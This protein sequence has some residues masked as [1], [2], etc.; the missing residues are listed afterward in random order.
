MVSLSRPSPFSVIRNSMRGF[1]ALTIN[2][3]RAS[4]SFF[5]VPIA[6]VAFTVT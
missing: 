4:R 3:P 5:I 2:S 1:S 6:T